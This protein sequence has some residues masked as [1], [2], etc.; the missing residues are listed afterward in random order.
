MDHS[1]WRCSKQ[2]QRQCNCFWPCRFRHSNAQHPGLPPRG[3][4]AAAATI[5]PGAKQEQAMLRSHHGFDA[6]RLISRVPDCRWSIRFGYLKRFDCLP[7]R[8]KYRVMCDS[9]RNRLDIRHILPILLVRPAVAIPTR[10]H[11]EGEHSGAGLAQKSSSPACCVGL[12]GH[13]IKRDTPC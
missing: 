3:R 4:A 13:V 2:G 6:L 12:C 10:L 1:A 8:T 11:G 9:V 7:N 5:Q